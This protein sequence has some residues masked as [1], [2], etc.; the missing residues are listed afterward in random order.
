VHLLATECANRQLPLVTF[1]S[2]LVFD[3]LKNKPYVEGDQKGPLCVYGESQAWAE[4]VVAETLPSCLII[5][6]SAS[7]APWDEHN[8]VT[9][10]LGVLAAGKELVV[11]GDVTVSLSY[12]PDLVNTTLDLL[13]DGE[14]GIWHLANVGQG[15][16]AG[17]IEDCASRAALP[18]DLVRVCRLEDLHLSARRPTFSALGSERGELMPTLDEALNR[19]FRDCKVMCKPPLALQ[20]RAA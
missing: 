16:W 14:R 10:A 9:R 15:T 5:R 12:L 2:H 4:D 1:S 18:T 11:A 7:F 3:G 8:F 17:I 19:Y 6:S 13:I 20:K